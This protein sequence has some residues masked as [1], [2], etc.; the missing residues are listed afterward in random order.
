MYI[1]VIG[2]SC[3]YVLIGHN[4]HTLLILSKKWWSVET[5]TCMARDTHMYVHVS[6]LASYV[7]IHLSSN[8]LEYFSKQLC[9]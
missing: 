9:Y 3:E 4:S 2:V 7:C 8:D 1:H 5:G 6:L